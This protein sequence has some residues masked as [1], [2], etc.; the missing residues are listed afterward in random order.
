MAAWSVRT[1]LLSWIASYLS[2]AA[3]ACGQAVNSGLILQIR[4]AASACPDPKACAINIMII[5]S[6]FARHR[7]SSSAKWALI[8]RLCALPISVTWWQP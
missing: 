6:S 7:Q 5:I 4:A 2:F 1:T 8:R 3:N